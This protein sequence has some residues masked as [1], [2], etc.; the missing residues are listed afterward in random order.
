MVKIHNPASHTVPKTL[1]ANFDEL[2]RLARISNSNKLVHCIGEKKIID[3]PESSDPRSKAGCPTADP[4]PSDQPNPRAPN[5]RAPW[6]PPS[7]P[8]PPPASPASQSPPPPPS[9]R[10][11][12][13]RPAGPWRRSWSADG[14]CGA[15][16]RA[17]L[18]QASGRKP[19]STVEPV[20]SVETCCG[21]CEVQDF[22]AFPQQEAH[23]QIGMLAKSQI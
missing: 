2:V 1:P 8:P 4:G 17:Q 18:R 21:T 23:H 3:P 13:R 19:W 14:V 11:W 9:P 6:P 12:R 10:W 16:G 7:P 5:P 15:P 22:S 20:W